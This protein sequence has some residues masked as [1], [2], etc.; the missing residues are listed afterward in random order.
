MATDLQGVIQFFR[1]KHGFERILES[2]FDLFVQHGRAFGAARLFTPTTEE[3]TAISDFFNRDYYDQALI[4]IGLADFERQ[5]QKNFS[6]TVT[7]ESF[8]SGYIG[9]PIKP[10]Q[11]SKPSAFA[12]VVLTEIAP[13]FE[14]TAAESWLKEISIQTRRAYRQL[15]EQY[16]TRP[17][18]ILNMI[19]TTAKTYNDLGDE[20]ITLAEFSKKNM[21]AEDALDFTSPYGKLFLK[22]LAF[23]FKQPVPEATEDCISL[24]LRAKLISCG[25]LSH[26]TI[27]P[28]GKSEAIVL[29]LENLHSRS[30]FSNFGDKIYIIEDALIFSKMRMEEGTV[31]CP[32][33]GLN[34]A[35]MYLLLQL[36][37]TPFYYAGNMTYKGL[38]QADKLYLKFKNFIPWRYDP[39]D[40]AFITSEDFFFLPDEKRSLALHNETLASLLSNIRKTGK[41]A[42]SMPLVHKYADDIRRGGGQSHIST[43]R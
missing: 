12:Y 15:A 20:Y 25:S 8:L 19:T 9:K 5:M 16:I 36:G 31:I 10:P 41:T 22:A 3:E 1:Q 43:R 34:A 38:E 40:Y 4:R 6:T 29:T 39:E 11:D 27:K 28:C 18:K 32:T 24:H 30:D 37:E 7:L 42:N 33:G 21:G 13:K 17:E 14:D 2:M 35:F 23:K 26:V